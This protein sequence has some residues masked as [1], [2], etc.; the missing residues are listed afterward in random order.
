MVF[1]QLGVHDAGHFDGDLHVV[2]STVGMGVDDLDPLVHRRP[3]RHRVH[4][5]QRLHDHL[6][7]RINDDFA[8]RLDS[9][10][11]QVSNR[12]PACGAAETE[13]RSDDPGCYGR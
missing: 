3:R 9:H 8:R 10:C 2:R 11:H 12:G 13:S 1:E 4:V 7:G 6:R 5:G